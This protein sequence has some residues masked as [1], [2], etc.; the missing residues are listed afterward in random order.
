MKIPFLKSKKG[1]II[2]VRIEPRSTKAG[3]SGFVGDALK[4]KVH[5]PPLKGAAN[6]ELLEL[7]SETFSIKKSAMKIIKGDTSKNKLVEIEGI[8]SIP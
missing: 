6:E 4:V 7:L 2:K 5:S 8:N 1:I 3:I